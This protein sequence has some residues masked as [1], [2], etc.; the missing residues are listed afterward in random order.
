[1][2]PCDNAQQPTIAMCLP[3]ATNM[4]RS[5]VCSFFNSLRCRAHGI[6]AQAL[7]I[8]LTICCLS[9]AGYCH[10]GT[11]IEDKGLSSAEEVFKSQV[12]PVVEGSSEL[13]PP[14][15]NNY[16]H[17]RR[18]VDLTQTRAFHMVKEN[19]VTGAA[20]VRGGG[21]V[22]ADRLGPKDM[23]LKMARPFGLRK[24]IYQMGRG[25][26]GATLEVH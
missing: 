16:N 13:F 9:A 23:C 11:S 26:V 2:P 10:I 6:S 8:L 3:A 12:Q 7:K 15:Y 19:W 25:G 17:F 20:E 21:G 24:G 5:T 4:N 22:T 1:M 14:P 18:A